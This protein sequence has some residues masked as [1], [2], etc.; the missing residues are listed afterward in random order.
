MIHSF[1]RILEIVT[2]LGSL[3]SACY[4]LV[5]LWSASTF[6]SERKG[7]RHVDTGVPFPPVSIL[8]P[9]KGVDPDIYQSFR[10]HCIQEY[11]EY[12]IVFGVSDANDPA[13]ASVEKLKKEFPQ[14]AIRVMICSDRLGPNMKVSNLEQMAQGSRYGF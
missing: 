12:E 11:P 5:C 10:S 2:T 4:Y 1:S 14:K 3:A 13:I 9:L 6:L 7:Q 8:K